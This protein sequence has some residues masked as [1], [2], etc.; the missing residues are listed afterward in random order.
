M[1]RYLPNHIFNLSDASRA[2]RHSCI[3]MH[4]LSPDASGSNFSPYLNPV[5][6][7]RTS[8]TERSLI[9]GFQG[10]VMSTA[11]PNAWLLNFWGPVWP[12]FVAIYLGTNPPIPVISF[13]T[14]EA[15]PGDHSFNVFSTSGSRVRIF[16]CS[17]PF[18]LFSRKFAGPI[19]EKIVSN[20]VLYPY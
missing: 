2:A 14:R 13:A 4:F 15:S 5:I 7:V 1:G 16:S 10:E 20:G 18:T 8:I 19:L 11:S 9:C 3:A 12:S 17:P 6:F